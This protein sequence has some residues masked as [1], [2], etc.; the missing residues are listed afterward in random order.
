V[1]STSHTRQAARLLAQIKDR[2]TATPPSAESRALG[3]GAVETA[4]RAR[5]RRQRTLRWTAI[6]AAAVIVA[7]LAGSEALRSHLASRARGGTGE[8][9]SVAVV[10][11]PVGK[12]LVVSRSIRVALVDGRVLSAGTRVLTSAQGT[13]VLALS[14][15]TRMQI[16]ADTDLGVVES[17]ATQRFT[18]AA[19]VLRAH[20]A[21]LHVGE[22]FVIVTPD[23]EVEVRGT[24]FRTEVVPA[25]HACAGGVRTRVEV[26]EGIVTVRHQGVTV[27]VPAGVSWPAWCRSGEEPRAARGDSASPPPR[28]SAIQPPSAPVILPHVPARGTPTSAAVQDRTAGASRILTGPEELPASRPPS[29]SLADQNDAYEH[30]LHAAQQGDPGAA[31][32]AFDRFLDRYPEGPLT[33]SAWV[34]RLR[35]AAR[36]D[37]E[38]ARAL[39]RRYLETFPTGAARA[40]AQEIENGDR[41]MG[42]K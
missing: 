21:K 16:A 36:L 4:I 23:A 14:T 18:L 38:R 28:S 12:A 40:E 9:D 19:G 8:P 2:G 41:I 27:Q 25:E 32:V 11:H 5:A 31:I 10:A 37:P 15:G 30:A 20:V 29:S 26:E 7:A 24:S 42:H 34:E 22:R 3:V 6:A 13:A 35:I 1:T 33:E 17:R 39:A